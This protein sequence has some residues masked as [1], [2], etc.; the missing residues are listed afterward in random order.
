VRKNLK[1]ALQQRSGTDE[2]KSD[3]RRI[4][5]ITRQWTRKS[6]ILT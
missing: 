5:W 3:T 6:K 4:K 1:E 2:Q